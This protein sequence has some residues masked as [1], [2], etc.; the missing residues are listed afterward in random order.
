MSKFIISSFKS[1]GKFVFGTNIKDYS[2]SN[3]L[4]EKCADITGWDEYRLDNSLTLYTEN[5]I[6]I[7]IMCYKDCC[8]NNYQLIG[9]EFTHFLQFFNI[10]LNSLFVERIFIENRNCYQDVYEIDTLGIQIWCEYNVIAS[11]VCFPYVND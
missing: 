7:S 3:F 2:E 5:G 8:L 9:A 1:V 6:I 10:D 4:F 11:V